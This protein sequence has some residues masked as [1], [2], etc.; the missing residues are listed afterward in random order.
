MEDLIQYLQGL[1]IRPLIRIACAIFTIATLIGIAFACVI[2]YQL[3]FPR[4]KRSLWD[5]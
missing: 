1:P 5:N 2:L 4:K 3:L